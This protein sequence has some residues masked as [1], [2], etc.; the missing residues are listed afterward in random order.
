MPSK[1]SFLI[2]VVALV[3]WGQL[4]DG[5]DLLLLARAFCWAMLGLSAWLLLRVGGR[6]S[7]G[8]AAFQG[9]AAY[10]VGLSATTWELDNFWVVLALA[11]GA[12]GV[13]GA[14]VGWVSSRLTGFHFL[15]ITLAFAEMLRSLALRWR[16]LGGEDGI[17]GITRPSTWPLPVDLADSRHLMWFTGVLMV[18]VLLGLVLLLRSPFGAALIGV[19]DSETRMASLGYAPT[20]YRIV[21]VVMAS[22]IAGLAGTLNAYAVRFVS[23]ADFV[24]L[25]SAKALLFTVIGGAGMLGAVVAA[26]VMTFLE[27]DLSSRWDRWPM[28][29]GAVYVALAMI[30]QGPAHRVRGIGRRMVA[31]ARRQPAAA[32]TAVAPLNPMHR[33]PAVA[34]RV[35]VEVDR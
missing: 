6:A 18:V 5:F 25:V 7:L 9:T 22:M 35:P 8:T 3:V 19:R 33:V 4:V 17:S 29:L 23:P 26:C 24:P 27:D 34:R 2:L 15:L 28:I 16:T 30:G 31:A 20:P 1:R 12:A 14:I 13:L 10:V 11:L 32:P 21:A